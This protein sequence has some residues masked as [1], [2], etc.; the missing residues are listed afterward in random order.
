MAD[1]EE[2][3]CKFV[4]LKADISTT[5]IEFLKGGKLS[6]NNPLESCRILYKLTKNKD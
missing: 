3:W 5:K 2:I 6:S 1:A 4:T